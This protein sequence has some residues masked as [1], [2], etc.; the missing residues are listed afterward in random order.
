MDCKGKIVQITFFEI[1]YG[2]KNRRKNIWGENKLLDPSQ[3]KQKNGKKQN[4]IICFDGAFHG[5]TVGAQ[6]MT[7]SEAARA[8]IG[9][10]D[11]EIHHLP[12]PYPWESGM[13]SPKKFF[14]DTLVQLLDNKGLDP[15][16]DLC[17]FFEYL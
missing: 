17:G 4:G 8:W 1:T 14:Q 2:Y 13:T 16:A 12:F 6:M 5:R 11:P 3:R 15:V 9:Y 7:G 10:H